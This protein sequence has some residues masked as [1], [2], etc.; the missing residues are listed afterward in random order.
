MIVKQNFELTN[1]NTFGLVVN[2]KEAA[3]ITSCDDLTELYNNGKLNKTNILTLS[4]GSNILFTKDYNGLVVLN[5]IYGKRII[6]EDD[7]HVFLE[8]SSGEIWSDIV[9]FAVSNNWGGLENMIDIPGKVGAAPV[10]NIGAYGT[11]LKDVMASLEAFEISTG[12]FVVI[13]NK[14]CNFGYRS[15]IFKTTHKNKYI[16]TK[17]ILRLHKKPIL[18]LSYKPLA[19]AF[20]GKDRATITIGDVSNKISEIRASKIPDPVCFHNAGS[21]FK[22]PIVSMSKFNEFTNQFP[23]IPFFK[24][25]NNEVKIPAGWLIEQCGWKGKRIGDVGT[26]EKQALILINY[27][28]ATGKQILDFATNIQ[29]SVANKF[30]INLDLEVNVL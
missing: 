19:D 3:I 4:G 12:Q 5:N 30:G 23:K 10:Q 9:D 29:H 18:N 6:E 25:S 8:V 1:N 2:A 16:I 26:S 21:F 22:N 27:G 15:S 7:K 17:I 14:D 28:T 11:E 20:A 13:K 24:I